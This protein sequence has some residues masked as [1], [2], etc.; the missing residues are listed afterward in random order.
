MR[1]YIYVCDVCVGVDQ[2]PTCNCVFTWSCLGCTSFHLVFADC[3]AS[4]PIGT[5]HPAP[6]CSS[7]GGQG[8]PAAAELSRFLAATGLIWLD[9]CELPQVVD[10][11]FT[12]ENI[13]IYHDRCGFGAS[14]VAFT[15][16]FMDLLVFSYTNGK[17]LSG[18]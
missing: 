1:I 13:M 11:Q 18:K 17:S 7:S 6:H 2:Y 3:T 10:G 4:G 9:A 16:K 8:G 12:W 15:P 5:D 14:L